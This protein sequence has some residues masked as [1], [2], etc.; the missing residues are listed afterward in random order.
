MVPHRSTNWAILWLTSQIGRDAVLSQFYGRGWSVSVCAVLVLSGRWLAGDWP[1]AACMRNPE[2]CGLCPGAWPGR[3]PT[4]AA[5]AALQALPWGP[6]PSLFVDNCRYMV[7][8][9]GC[10]LGGVHGGVGEWA[11]GGLGLWTRGVDDILSCAFWHR[12]SVGGW[13]RRAKGELV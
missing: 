9:L 3:G 4:L 10:P 11:G 8:L 7:L 2:P 13:R 5:S 6:N 1:A 12:A